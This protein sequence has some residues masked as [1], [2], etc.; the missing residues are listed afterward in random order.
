MAIFHL[1]VS[2]DLNLQSHLDIQKLLVLTQV[3]RNFLLG[4][5][6]LELQGLN[7]S[8]SGNRGY[9]MNVLL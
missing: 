1:P 8:L 6:Q 4:G 7:P 3:Q 2:C 5:F 9:K